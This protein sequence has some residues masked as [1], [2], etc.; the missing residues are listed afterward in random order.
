MSKTLYE[1]YEVIL[2]RKINPQE[3][4]Y[5]SYLFREGLDKILKKCGEEATEVVIAA[6]NGKSEELAGE[7][8]DLIYHL[9]VLMAETGLTMGEL[10]ALLEERRQK[11]GNLKQQLISTKN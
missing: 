8:G 4:S 9:L 11:V 3:G 5:T 7:I 1:L 10:N 6:K 2:E